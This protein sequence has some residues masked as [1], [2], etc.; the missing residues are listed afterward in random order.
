MNNFTLSTTKIFSRKLFFLLFTLILSLSG[1]AQNVGI[2][3]IG[4]QP[5]SA[6]GLDIDFADKGLLIPRVILI[7]TTSSSPLASHVAGMVVYN[8]ATTGDVKP[9]F[10]CDNGSRWIPGFLTGNSVGDMLYWDGA[11]W[12]MIPVGQPGEYL[13]ISAS[14][15]PVWGGN[16]YAALTT[17]SISSITI[18]TAAC[19]GNITSNGGSAIVSRGVCWSTTQHPTIANSKTTDGSGNGAFTSSLTGLTSGTVYYARAYAMNS[20]AISYGNEVSFTTIANLPS[21]AATTAATSVTGTTAISG[22]NVTSNGGATITERGICYGTASNPTIVNSKVIDASPGTGSFVSNI[23][24]LLGG[25]LYYVRAYA[26][27]LMGTSYGTQISF[28]IIRDQSHV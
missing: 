13:K 11:Q 5:N 7:G 28:T 27:N 26:T 23:S 17:N 16:S 2:N 18:T 6:A 20:S 21:L 24:G 19:G 10:Y 12:V 22:G 25:T 3:S 1:F 9:G 14:N 8:T 4:A 15:I